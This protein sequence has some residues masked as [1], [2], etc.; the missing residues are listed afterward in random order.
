[1]QSLKQQITILV[2]ASTFLLAMTFMFAIGMQIKDTAVLA[3]ITKAKS[4]LSTGEALI[5]HQYPGPWKVENGFLYKGEV[6]I[7]NNNEIVD[8][9]SNLTGNTSTI[10][11]GRTRVATTV[12]KENGERAVGTHA[13]E[14]VVKKVLA[15]GR[16]YLGEAEVVGQRYQTA[17]KPLFDQNGS[18][19]G[20]FY[21]GISKK[22]YDT[23]FYE[24]IWRMAIIG[25]GLTVLV[26]FGTMYF[27]KRVITEPIKLLTE[28]TQNFAKGDFCSLYYPARMDSNNEIGE[29]ARSIKQ[30]GE[31]VQ[32]LTNQLNN[33]SF[34]E[35]Q[36]T[37]LITSGSEAATEE[38]CE[39]CIKKNGNRQKKW[40]EVTKGLNEVTLSQIL[41]FMKDKD[42]SLSASDIAG[43]VKL[44]KVTVRRYLEFMEKCGKVTVD[45]QY[46]PVGRPLKL[47][48]LNL[49][50]N[51]L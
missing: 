2:V 32:V 43:E 27:I 33:I 25:C 17:Y 9:I 28:E 50:D 49:K 39:N 35:A 14:E 44:T 20:M 48:K 5:N 29:L 16:E 31:W 8:Y 42:D 6:K 22:F 24:S 34:E 23:L 40:S 36:S 37:E 38:E 3:C 10:F 11:L 26:F 1:M 12:K 47:Y 45:M 4:D 7:N 18:I 13:S 41:T 51:D 19:I 15:E 21:V 46:G 30:M